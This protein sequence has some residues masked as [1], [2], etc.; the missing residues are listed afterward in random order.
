MQE[1]EDKNSE[2]VQIFKI[3]E[4]SN[5][6]LDII[7]TLL[8]YIVTF[9]GEIEPQIPDQVQCYRF[10]L[11]LMFI[12]LQDKDLPE[13]ELSIKKFLE[14]Y[15]IKYQ[16]RNNA[17]SVEDYSELIKSISYG[18][19]GFNAYILFYITIFSFD[20]KKNKLITSNNYTEK[21][22]E[23]IMKVL[24]EKVNEKLVKLNGE[25]KVYI[26][27]MKANKVHHILSQNIIKYSGKK[28]IIFRNYIKLY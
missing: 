16:E 26:H 28:F 11:A 9:H 7:R 19:F 5:P 20:A 10:E 14:H 24:Y 4:T 6:G 23:E 13:N 1:V 17:S 27:D 21:S 18:I 25:K 12:I 22:D 15:L 8:S 2:S 3:V